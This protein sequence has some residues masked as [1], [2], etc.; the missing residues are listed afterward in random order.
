M[1][2]FSGDPQNGTPNFR[3]PPNLGGCVCIYY[4]NENGSEMAGL[5]IY[6]MPEVCPV[7]RP[8]SLRA[9]FDT[10][11][12]QFSAPF[13]SRLCRALLAV[14]AEQAIVFLLLMPQALHFVQLQTI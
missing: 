9:S 1:T 8:C 3:K 5:L 12:F 10:A 11:K 14:A 7:P 6:K 4:G 2:A 13:R